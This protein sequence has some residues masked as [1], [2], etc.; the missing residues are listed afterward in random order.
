MT[1][2]L[3]WWDADL[4]ALSSERIVGLIV[5]TTTDWGNSSRDG[6]TRSRRRWLMMADDGGARRQV[7]DFAITN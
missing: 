5:G 7:R 1:L 6:R 2:L 3:I 4:D